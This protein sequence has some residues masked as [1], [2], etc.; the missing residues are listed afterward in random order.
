MSHANRGKGWEQLLEMYH[1]RY[2]AQ[3]RAV[4]IRTPPPM[5]ILRAIKPGQFL[6]V[7]SSAGPPD[8]MALAGGVAFLVEA[9]ECNA[10]RWA[11]KNLHPHQGMRLDQWEAQGGRGAVLL[12]HVRSSSAWVLP[13]YR[14]SPIWNRW[15]EKHSKG[16]RAASGTASLG[17]A[18]FLQIGLPFGQDGWLSQALR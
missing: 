3:G 1:A 4:V 2:E 7:Y 10:E 12:H 16:Q 8:Y 6:A 13:W 11:L 14:L 18:D 9:K 17:R 15:H 5:R